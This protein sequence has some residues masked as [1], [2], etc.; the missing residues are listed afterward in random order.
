ML[1]AFVAIVGGCWILLSINDLGTGILYS[2]LWTFVVFLVARLL[3]AIGFGYNR[4]TRGR[5]ST[6]QPADVAAALAELTD[7]RD[8]ELISTEEYEAKR[9]K[10]VERL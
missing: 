4:R 1:A 7:L 3:L 8:R 10:I 2:A 5:E 9:A 6:G